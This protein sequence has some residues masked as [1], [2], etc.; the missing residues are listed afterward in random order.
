[1]NSE[2]ELSF[3]IHILNQPHQVF[4]RLYDVI[5]ICKCIIIMN[6]EN[7]ILWSEIIKIIKMFM[8]VLPLYIFRHVDK[9]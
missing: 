5:V 9:K 2:W 8:N 1:M 3:H 7:P 4:V 6:Q